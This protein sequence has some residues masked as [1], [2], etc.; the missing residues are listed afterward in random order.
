MALKIFLSLSYVDRDFVTEV[1]ARLPAGLSYFYEESFENGEILIRAME[2]AV[3][4]SAIFV[5]FASKHAGASPWV[6][7]EID[8]A[9]I[10]QI[11]KPNHRILVFPTDPSVA[12][13]RSADV[14]TFSL[15][16]SSRLDA[17]RHRSIHHNCAS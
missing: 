7:F 8:L 9:R 5:L 12:L 15:D 3:S 4:D 16:S 14:A 2:R 1:R 11:R 10:E 13:K 17:G 6:K